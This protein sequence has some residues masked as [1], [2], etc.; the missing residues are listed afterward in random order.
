MFGGFGKE[1]IS[2]RALNLPSLGQPSRGAAAAVK[3]QAGGEGGFVGMLCPTSVSGV[4]VNETH[5]LT[6]ARPH[7]KCDVIRHLIQKSPEGN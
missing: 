2:S 6:L 3:I 7:I 5:P 1:N 4:F